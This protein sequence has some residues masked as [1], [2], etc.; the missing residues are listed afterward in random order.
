MPISMKR[1]RKWEKLQRMTVGRGIALWRG[2]WASDVWRCE[3][4]SCGRIWEKEVRDG[5]A[6]PESPRGCA[7]QA[8]ASLRRQ[9][10]RLGNGRGGGRGGGSEIRGLVGSKSHRAMKATSHQDFIYYLER[11]GK[12]WEIVKRR[13]V[14]CASLCCK[15]H[16]LAL[17]MQDRKQ[18]GHLG[19]SY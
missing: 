16:V 9:G 17:G 11:D 8:W 5:I 3:G 10:W 14:S 13:Q 4:M 7:E 6:R 2:L 18:G 15:R 1:N 19:D 12:H